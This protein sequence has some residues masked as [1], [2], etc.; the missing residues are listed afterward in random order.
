[1]LHS[2]QYCGFLTIGLRFLKSNFDFLMK[3]KVL[4]IIKSLGRGGAEMLLPETLKFH[5][6]DTFEFHYIYFLPWKNQMVESIRA[7]GG[8]VTCFSAP[9][10]L[11]ILF[12]FPQI[13]RYV[14]KHQIQLIHCHL[15][16]AGFVGRIIY[17]LTGLPVLYTEHNKQER[18]HR[19]TKWLNRFSFNF[20]STVIAVSEDVAQS[21]QTNIRPQIPIVTILNG[22]DTDH[23]QYSDL[24]RKQIREQCQLLEDHFVIGTIAVF[25]FQKRLEEWLEVFAVIKQKYPFVK[26][27]IVGDGILK[28]RIIAKRNAL[29]LED[30]VIMPGLQINTVDWLSTMDLYMMTSLFEGLPVAMLE[31]MSCSLPVVSTDAGG[32]G[33]VIRNNTDGLL[34][35]VSRY[36]ELVNAASELITHAQ[37]RD[38]FRIASRNRVVSSFSMVKMVHHLETLYLHILK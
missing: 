29:G 7:Q 34:V 8:A 11:R 35:P 26:G 20:Q 13:I 18:Y 27:I 5:S 10:N 16:W 31:A 21:I 14:K 1:M 36:V 19:I 4:H 33:E 17:K 9:N 30:D 38:E 3:V 37:R 22:V 23:Y 25:R 24:K 32:I 2:I 15:P 12:T 6:K 28:E